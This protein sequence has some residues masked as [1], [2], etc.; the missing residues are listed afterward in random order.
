MTTQAGKGD[1]HWRVSLSDGRSDT[2]KMAEGNGGN[3]ALMAALGHWLNEPVAAL[4]L[5]AAFLTYG[6]ASS[7]AAARLFAVAGQCEL[8]FCLWGPERLQR[9]ADE[10]KHWH[11]ESGALLVLVN[12]VMR[13]GTQ[14]DRP[15]L[16]PN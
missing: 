8:P 15:S 16:E 12:Q 10:F 2:E 5:S 14:E 7:Y 4:L 9:V 3:K 11:P 13:L 6:V 1:A